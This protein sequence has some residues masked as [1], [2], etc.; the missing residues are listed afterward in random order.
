[1]LGAAVSPPATRL[2][3]R[4]PAAAAPTVLHL[5]LS[6]SAAMRLAPVAA[7][8]RGAQPLVDSAGRIT[9]WAGTEPPDVV[10]GPRSPVTTAQAVAAAVERL[11]P[12][13]ALIAGDD[14]L[15]LAGALAAASAGVPIARLG[16]GLRCGDRGIGRE[17]NR[18]AIDELATR[19]YTDSEAAD[20]QL[21]AEGI[22]EH[23]VRRV[24]CTLSAAIAR[25][26]GAALEQEAWTRIGVSRR[27]YVLVSLHRRESFT[28]AGR[29]ADALAALAERH[30]VVLCTDDRW[31][32]HFAPPGTIVAAPRDYVEF[33]SLEIGA[34][35]VLTDSAG[36]QEE[37]TMLGVRC[38]TL[39]HSSERTTTLAYGTN[40]L[41]GDD[42]D[43]I[44]EVTIDGLDLVVDRTPLW[45][46][47]A[48]R[49]VAADLLAAPWE[50]A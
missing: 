3:R 47:D 4:G 13:V 18:I 25:W 8:Q 14:D 7:C 48:G 40:T 32:S 29:L 22:D 44:A 28:H 17:I 27:E 46:G 42:P 38:F 43:A 39:A 2:A 6:R 49:R 34:G 12:D 41:L 31:P 5:A 37:T 9:T 36:L 21:R 50:D 11:R 30:P 1:M 10:P 26:R 33:L 45:D 23:K 19:L 16:A 20:E 35:A 24:G 15:A